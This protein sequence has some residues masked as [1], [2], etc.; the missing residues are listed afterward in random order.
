M[1][2]GEGTK[3]E[4]NMTLKCKTCIYRKK[5][6][7]KFLFYCKKG[8]IRIGKQRKYCELYEPK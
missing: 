6:M 5:I 8:H 1:T 2:A 4:K 7:K 3:K